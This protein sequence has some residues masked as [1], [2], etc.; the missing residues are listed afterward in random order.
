M[1][2]LTSSTAR[3]FRNVRFL[4]TDMDE[5]L[6]HHGRISAAV[7]SA[8]ERLRE[9]DV[10]VIVV[11]AAPA[12]WCDQ[13]A[14]MWPV[15]GVIG[16]NGGFFFHRNG[17]QLVRKY[18]HGDDE[19]ERCSRE[20][21]TIGNHVRAALPG[22]RLAD[23]QPYRSTSLAF[24]RTW[25]SKTDNAIMIALL[26]AGL[27]ATRNNRWLLAW[28]GAYNKLNMA[29]RVLVDH[30]GLNHAAA[31]EAVCYS[32]DS[33]NDVP[34]FRFFRRSVGMRTVQDEPLSSYP[35]WITRGPGGAGFVE[36]AEAILASRSYP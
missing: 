10:R 29:S 21:E 35:A 2:E 36:V 27:S 33:E 19:R 26:N 4:L 34:M 6:T 28:L 31:R 13:M 12:G 23:D 18:W 8:L 20:L 24:I 30:F 14:R 9:S 15:D 5:T 1:R 16:E 11:T 3:D 7:F 22:A 32:G 25:S 17:A